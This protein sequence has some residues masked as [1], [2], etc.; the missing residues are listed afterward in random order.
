[1][2]FPGSRP[3]IWRST[4]TSPAGSV[5]GTLLLMISA[6]PYVICCWYDTG[7]PDI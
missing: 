2:H 7:H 4:P 5:R 1:L 3:W 6:L